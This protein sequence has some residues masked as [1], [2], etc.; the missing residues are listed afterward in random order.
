MGGQFECKIR[1]FPIE[2]LRRFRDHSAMIRFI[3][4]SEILALF[5]GSLSF[6]DSAFSALRLVEAQPYARTSKILEIHGDRGEPLPNEWIILLSDSS[7]RSGL[8]EVT[9]ANGK[10]TSERTPLHEQ[11]EATSMSPIEPS[12]LSFDADQVFHAV[13]REAV[14]KKVGFDWI[15]YTLRMDPESDVPVWHVKIYDNMGAAVGRMRLSAQGGTVIRAL[16]IDGGAYSRAENQPPESRI[17]GV[18][19]AVGDSANRAATVVKDSTL[20]FIGNVQEVLVGERT[21]GPKE[22]DEE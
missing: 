10:I 3:I 9:V 13:E 18:V 11:I 4:F 17:G 8:R 15:D 6:A 16:Q 22:E 2:N 7:S 1:E 19:G 14:R 5:T 21:I 20:R 12:K